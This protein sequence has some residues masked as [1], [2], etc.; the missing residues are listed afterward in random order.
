MKNFCERFNLKNLIQD[1]TL[2][3]KGENEYCDSLDVKDIR[4]MESPGKP[5]NCC[6]QINQNLEGQ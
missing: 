5:L 6:F 4:V 2:T 1:L 3:R